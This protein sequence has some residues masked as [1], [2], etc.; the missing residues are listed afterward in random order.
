ME[1]KGFTLI[2]TM[3]VFVTLGIIAA[4]VMPGCG[5]HIDY[6]DGE[7]TGVIYKL[8]NKGMICKTWEGEM[9]LGGASADGNGQMVPNQWR[10]T[11]KDKSILPKI[12]EA[13]KSGKRIT[14]HY[15][16]VVGN[17][18]CETSS[19]GYFVDKVIE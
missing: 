9:N 2:E 5:L 7:R 18:P 10:F 19:G 15:K 1:Q 12:Q 3:I 6:S 16:E 14:V 8:S 13:A 11:V 17:W 4:A